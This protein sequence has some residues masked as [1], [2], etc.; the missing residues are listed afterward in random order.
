MC[1]DGMYNRV[2]LEEINKI[3]K[4]TVLSTKEKLTEL[5]ILSKSKDEKDN[6]TG[7]FIEV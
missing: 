4:S 1:S 6:I 3:A 5:T 2:D 7:I